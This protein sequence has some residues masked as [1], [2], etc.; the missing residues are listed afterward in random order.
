[1]AIKLRDYQQRIINKASQYV[2]ENKG[3]RPCVVAPTGA[4]KSFLAAALIDRLHAT[5]TLLLTHQKE[6]LEQDAEAIKKLC[7]E[8]KVSFYSAAIGEKDFSGDIVAAGIASIFRSP[9]IPAFDLVIIDECHLINNNSTGMYRT[10]LDRLS[11]NT[12]TVITGLT[13]T[14]YRLGQGLLTDDG[15]FDDI[16]DVVS[17]SEL[18]SLGFLAHLTSKWTE[19]HY[20]FS[21]LRIRGGEFV[22]ADVQEAVSV[23]HTN[24]EVAKEI[25]AKGQNRKAWLIFC[26]GVAHAQTMAS[27]LNQY[28]IPSACVTGTTSK[29]E[30]EEI[31]ENF[32]AGNYRCVT[33]AK[34]L[35]TGFNYPDIDLIALLSPTLSPGLY[36]QEVGRGMRVKS[37]PSATCLILDFAGNVLR[38]GTVDA[39]VPPAKKKPGKG[40]APCKICQNCGEIVHASVK[41]CPS[42]GYQFESKPKVYCFDGSIMPEKQEEKNPI[43]IARCS[44]WRWDLYCSRKGNYCIRVRYIRQK[45]SFDKIYEYFNIWQQGRIGAK[46]RESLYKI[47]TVLNYR[48]N[49]DAKMMITELNRHEPPDFIKY[50]KADGYLKVISRIWNDNEVTA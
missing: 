18:Q 21:N 16:I 37:D 19:T 43:Y 40:V 24:E 38:H 39:V 10:V 26:A 6:L 35:T 34:V 11:A 23:L 15:F 48:G 22:D 27:L 12:G 2:E 7:P 9:I 28:G 49:S 33:N 44:A 32:K 25:I 3:K 29:K 41:I 45:S 20:D 36:L 8:K 4:G 13:A 14:P 1:M 42:C 47:F 46:A 30:R 31:L 5:K 17:I 50:K